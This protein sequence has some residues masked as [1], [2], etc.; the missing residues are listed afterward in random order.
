MISDTFIEI[1]EIS[2]QKSTR[3]QYYTAQ[4]RK[5]VHT[6]PKAYP[7]VCANNRLSPVGEGFTLPFFIKESF[8][9]MAGGETPPLQRLRGTVCPCAAVCFENY[10]N[11]DCP[12]GYLSVML[13]PPKN[14]SALKG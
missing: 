12:I 14:F 13:L 3:K 7:W 5:V 2:K 11:T 8:I 6:Q 10:P 1:S 9:P 4:M